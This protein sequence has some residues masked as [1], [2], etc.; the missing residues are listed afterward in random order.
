MKS[1]HPDYHE[2]AVIK[3]LNCSNEFKHG[4][5]RTDIQIE[6]CSKC[7]PFYTGKK[8]LI[9]TE[10]RV[11]KFRVKMEAAGGRTKKVRKKKTLADKVNEELTAQNLKEAAKTAKEEEAKAEKKAAKTAKEAPAVEEVAAVEETE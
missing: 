3:C 2:D 10:G 7:H 1:I 8:V 6:I 5:T 9:D 11:D 4:G